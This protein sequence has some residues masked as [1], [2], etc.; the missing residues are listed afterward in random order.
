MKKLLQTKF[1]VIAL[2]VAAPALALGTAAAVGSAGDDD[3][4]AVLPAHVQLAADREDDVAEAA[5]DAAEDQ[6]K[7]KELRQQSDPA[8]TEEQDNEVEDGDENEVDQ[9]EANDNEDED[10]DDEDEGEQDD[11]DDED[12]G[13]SDDEGDDD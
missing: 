2:C 6:A 7:P 10:E 11:D 12:Q 5:E 3:P 4:V 9:P 1:V 13:E 8:D